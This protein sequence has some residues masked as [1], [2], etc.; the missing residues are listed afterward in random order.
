MLKDLSSKLI[1]VLPYETEKDFSSSY[2]FILLQKQMDRKLQYV[3]RKSFH[4]R[5]S[6]I[7]KLYRTTEFFS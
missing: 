5:F 6:K 7:F 1:L 3:R 2:L 4:F